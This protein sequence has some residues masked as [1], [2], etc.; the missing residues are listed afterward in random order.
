MVV[1]E[2]F[3]AGG[4]SVEA[5]FSR[6]VELQNPVAW[7]EAGIGRTTACFYGFAPFSLQRKSKSC[8]RT[9][10]ASVWIAIIC[11]WRGVDT[12]N[13]WTESV[14]IRGLRC[15]SAQTGPSRVTIGTDFR[16]GMRGTWGRRWGG[17]ETWR[18]P[19]G[20]PES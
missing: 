6:K 14:F 4:S 7:E 12:S 1:S 19:R 20:K 2:R 10:W 9:T 17:G 11:H 16:H 3:E 18:K 8:G 13:V 15:K 5:T